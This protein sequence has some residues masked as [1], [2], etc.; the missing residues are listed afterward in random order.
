L[1]KEE[2]EEEEKKEKESVTTEGIG[3]VYGEIEGEKFQYIQI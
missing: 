1:K 2:E 3:T